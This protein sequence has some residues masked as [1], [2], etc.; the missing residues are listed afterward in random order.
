M[1]NP[2]I[3]PNPAYRKKPRFRNL[4]LLLGVI[5]LIAIFLNQYDFNSPGKL[6]VDPALAPPV[7]EGREVTVAGNT[8]GYTIVIDAGHG[9]KDPGANGAS[10]AEEKDYT[11]ALAK[12]VYALLQQD[13]KFD[14]YM[15]RDDD[16]FL[17]L[18]ERSAYSNELE[19]DAFL[20]I[21]GNTYTDPGI[22]GTETYYDSLISI[23][24]ANAIH[25]KLI[26]A[27]GFP[28]RGVK[29][30][31]WRV[32][33]GSERPSVLLEV[34]FMTNPQEEAKMLED[35]WQDRVAQSIVDGLKQYFE[36]K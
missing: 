29:Q 10:G 11:L 24:L 31:Q 28:D 19:A 20:S 3:R 7:S 34:G 32:L 6:V 15:T 21:H 17:E 13:P 1:M 33:V 26:D 27:T 22:S 4:F 23:P 12:K 2:N 18:D 9:G 8:G 5:A 14:P 35:D 25:S 30:E 16:I 36:G